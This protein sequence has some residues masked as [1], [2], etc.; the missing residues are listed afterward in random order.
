M[1][2][3]VFSFFLAGHARVCGI[4]GCNLP[5]LLNWLWSH[6]HTVAD[7]KIETKKLVQAKQLSGVLVLYLILSSGHF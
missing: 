3:L 1:L 7:M 2:P 6:F 5:G 4:L